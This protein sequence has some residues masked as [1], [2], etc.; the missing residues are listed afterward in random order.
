MKKQN[1]NKTGTANKS[2]VYVPWHLFLDSSLFSLPGTACAGFRP[3]YSCQYSGAIFRVTN[4]QVA[5]H[6]KG[7]ITSRFSFIFFFV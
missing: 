5:S 1:Q 6:F 4:R 2:E 3:L 7:Q